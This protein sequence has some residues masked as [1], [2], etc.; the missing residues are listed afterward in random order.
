MSVCFFTFAIYSRPQNVPYRFMYHI[1]LNLNW[2][3]VG[4]VP[5]G[6][7]SMKRDIYD[8]SSVPYARVTCDT[9]QRIIAPTAQHTQQF[10]RGP[11]LGLCSALCCG[12]RNYEDKAE[13]K[14]T[15][16]LFANCKLF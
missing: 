13:N 2:G 6:R 14:I 4:S 5:C 9:S 1:L 11:T 10:Y 7:K 16:V 3:V 12:I 8:S 15:A